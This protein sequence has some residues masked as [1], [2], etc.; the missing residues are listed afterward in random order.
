MLFCG[1][2]NYVEC[3]S[4]RSRCWHPIARVLG[5]SL[6]LDGSHFCASLGFLGQQVWN[7]KQKL[8]QFVKGFCG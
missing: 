5:R 2:E 6:F 7:V 8:R 1:D 3:F 4:S